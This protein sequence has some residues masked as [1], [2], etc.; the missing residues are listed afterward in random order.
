MCDKPG[1]HPEQDGH[2]GAGFNHRIA[3]DQLVG[4][5]MPRHDR[6]FDRPEQRRMQANQKEGA[7]QHRQAAHEETGTGNAHDEHFQNLH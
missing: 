6:V 4:M 5:E 7:H 3:T 1:Q 2:K